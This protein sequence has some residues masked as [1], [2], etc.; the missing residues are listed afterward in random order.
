MDDPELARYLAPRAP[1]RSADHEDTA[2]Q[3]LTDQLLHISPSSSTDPGPPRPNALAEYAAL[4][5]EMDT[6]MN[7]D[8][9][10]G[11]ELLRQRPDLPET[12]STAGPGTDI[13]VAGQTAP[14]EAQTPA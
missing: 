14:A 4:L 13:A 1:P 2:S 12:D 9:Q 11:P 5:A 6:S 7:G 8:G 3:E 10:G